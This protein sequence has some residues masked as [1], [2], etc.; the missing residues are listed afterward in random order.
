MSGEKSKNSGE[1]GEKIASS[2]LDKIGWRLSMHN[3]SITCNNPDHKNSSGNQRSSHGGDQIFVYHNPFHDDVTEFVHVSV[4]NTQNPYPTTES[5]RVKKI[6][7]DME[8]LHQIIECAEYSEALSNIEDQIQS[9]THIKH[10]G[11][12]IFLSDSTDELETNLRPELANI[13]L[14]RSSSV[15]I[16]FIDNARATFLLKAID[17][18]KRVTDAG[19][20]YEF[21]YPKIGTSISP[22]AEPK[23]SFIPLEMI[24]SETIIAIVSV[25]GRK[26]MSIYSNEMFSEDSYKKLLGYGLEFAR[27]LIGTINIGMSNFNPTLDMDSAKTVRLAFKDRTEK[28]QAFAL[29]RSILDLV[30]E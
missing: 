23:G 25:S 24:A 4:K 8:E 27:G 30:N 9:K 1:I 29:E 17:N 21:Y 5:A 22:E 12:L 20:T 6:K 11:V 13:R 15:P 16:Y 2:L 3:I 14:E 18:L 19:G 28:V 7:A 10:S 26:E